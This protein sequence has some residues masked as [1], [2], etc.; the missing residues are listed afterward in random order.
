M[1]PEEN[2]Y[3]FDNNNI[4]MQNN[5]NE[6]N[7]NHKK[8]FEKNDRKKENKGQYSRLYCKTT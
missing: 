5:N 6:E 8:S 1:R 3:E 7:Y 4:G 2:Q